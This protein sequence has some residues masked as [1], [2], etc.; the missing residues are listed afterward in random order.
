MDKAIIEKAWTG[1]RE[2]VKAVNEWCVK[3]DYFRVATF[4][5]GSQNY[6]VS[7]LKSDVDTKSIV[8]PKDFHSLMYN[9]CCSFKLMVSCSNN[10]TGEASV[11]DW[12]TFINCLKKGNPNFI[13]TLYTDFCDIAN[14][15]KCADAVR[16]L[17]E[18]RKEIARY[19]KEKTA[20][21]LRA[22]MNNAFNKYSLSP[23]GPVRAK[24]AMH[25][26]RLSYAL[27]WYYD[28]L[29]F[30]R[31]I[32]ESH[33]TPLLLRIR[34]DYSGMEFKTVIE[35]EHAYAYKLYYRDD[36]P[37]IL[38]NNKGNQK[39]LDKSFDYITEKLYRAQVLENS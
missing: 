6:G 24:K 3:N 20:S 14:D 39:E 23:P 26:V 36:K 27:S 29:D 10:T 18:N 19:N 28:G 33:I 7:T 12:I 2:H 1:L 21:A 15:E 31:C 4:L 35:Q 22:M 32:G 25:A 17:I 37:P 16:W 8:I 9:S 34:A 38:W 13:E 5:I 30:G 11:Q